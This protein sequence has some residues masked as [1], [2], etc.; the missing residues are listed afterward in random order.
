AITIL[1]SHNKRHETL[2]GKLGKFVAALLIF[3]VSMIFIEMI[4]LI[5]GGTE[6]GPAAFALLS[7]Q[8]SY[9]F[10]AL[11]ILL[12]G[13]LPIFILLNGKIG[14]TARAVASILILI[15]IYTMRHIIVIS[16][17]VIR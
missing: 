8:Y 2:I 3:E 1:L 7:G 9:L 12:G 14:R 4:V 10:W 11:E 5:K 6:T 13:L 16:E 17:Q 15:G